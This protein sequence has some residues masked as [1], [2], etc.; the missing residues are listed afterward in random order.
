MT[1]NERETVKPSN[2]PQNRVAILH[3]QIVSALLSNK[4]RTLANNVSAQSIYASYGVKP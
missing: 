1:T 4:N 3:Q 2:M